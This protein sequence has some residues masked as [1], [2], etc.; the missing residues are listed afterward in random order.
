MSATALPRH[1]GPSRGALTWDYL[2]GVT[3]AASM[4]A[5]LLA[6]APRLRP[7]Q[8]G[9]RRCATGCWH[10]GNHP[11]QREPL[12]P[13]VHG[14]SNGRSTRHGPRPGTC[15]RPCRTWLDAANDD[16]SPLWQALADERIAD[17]AE[18]P[19]TGVGLELERRLS[20]TFIRGRDLRHPRQH[21]LSRWTTTG[22]GVIHERRFGPNGVFEGETSL[23]NDD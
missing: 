15:A 10:L 6:D 17:D 7:V 23:R 19:E 1:T 12:A 8:P 4:T 20:P 13:G 2:A 22:R 14:I 3:H 16:L 21:A 5:D 11:L 18:L 9:A